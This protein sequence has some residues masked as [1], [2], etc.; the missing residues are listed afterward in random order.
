MSTGGFSPGVKLPGRKT[1]RTPPSSAEV[2]NA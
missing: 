2:K 1:D